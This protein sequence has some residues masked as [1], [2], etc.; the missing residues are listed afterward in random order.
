MESVDQSRWWV[1]WDQ[2][3]FELTAKWLAMRSRGDEWWVRW[4]LNPRP[5]A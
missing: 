5:I 4:D 3:K 2:N 1:M